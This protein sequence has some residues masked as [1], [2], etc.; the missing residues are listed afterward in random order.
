MP[1]FLMCA[2]CGAVYDTREP[3][4]S[5][6]YVRFGGH[7]WDHLHGEE[8]YPAKAFA[9]LTQLAEAV[10]HAERLRAITAVT[11]TPDR[12]VGDS[13]PLRER[14]V[15]AVRGEPGHPA[16]PLPVTLCGVGS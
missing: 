13:R 8:R 9:T 12:A 2:A 5:E 10:R 3:A 14:I 7:D 15:D 4:G 1:T 11:S 6:E 16:E